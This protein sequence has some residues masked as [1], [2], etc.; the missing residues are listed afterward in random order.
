LTDRSKETLSAKSPAQET[1]AD[2]GSTRLNV[3]VIDASR[4]HIPALQKM[5]ERANV[6][7]V[8][9]IRLEVGLQCL[10]DERFDV[11]MMDLIL[12]GMGPLE[13]LVCLTNSHPDVPVVVV[14]D[15]DDREIA[16]MALQEGAKD[17]LIKSELR[18]ATLIRSLR[19]A[20]ERRRR[21]RADEEVLVV[22]E[23]ERRRLS[24]ELHDGVIQTISTMRLQMQMLASEL[25]QRDN[26]TS[27]VVNRLADDAQAAI[28]EVRQVSRG[29]HSTLLEHQTLPD[30]LR[31]YAEDLKSQFTLRVDIRGQERD[32]ERTVKE[33]LYRICQ[34]C[35][36][37]SVGH[38][39]ANRIHVHFV[40][41]AER[42]VMEVRDNGQGF[43]LNL[44]SV[45]DGMGLSSIRERTTLLGGDVVVESHDGAGTSVRI[46]VPVPR[47]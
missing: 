18:Y 46:D 29:L 6:H 13:S 36:R 33:H 34:E 37:N 41:E 39:K 17:Y 2:P 12:P 22:Q 11:V 42:L 7:A 23:K 25:S 10:D 3:L 35:I 1:L 20:I 31:S 43:D 8:R 47:R 4:R 24:R 40:H 27:E 38:G 44:A 32:L 30:A 5:C 21:K 45:G 26:P 14:T 9:V 19:Y 15:L 16:N 28:N